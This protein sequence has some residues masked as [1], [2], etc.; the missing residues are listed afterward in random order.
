MIHLAEDN[1]AD[2]IKEAWL[3]KNYR[4]GYLLVAIGI[5]LSWSWKIHDYP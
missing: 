1:E 5:S 2:I 4:L 3:V